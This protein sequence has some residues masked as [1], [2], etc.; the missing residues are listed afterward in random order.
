MSDLY[1]DVA[2]LKREVAQLRRMLAD[3]GLTQ[4]RAELAPGAKKVRDAD[5]ACEALLGNIRVSSLA[6]RVPNTYQFI[7]IT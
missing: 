3:S 5:E 2:D 1:S 6:G 4:R 7:V